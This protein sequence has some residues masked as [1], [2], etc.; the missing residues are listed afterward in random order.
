MYMQ[1]KEKEKEKEKKERERERGGGG[2]RRKEEREGPTWAERGDRKKKQQNNAGPACRPAT[3]VLHTQVSFATTAGSPILGSCLLP[4]CIEAV[5]VG[6]KVSNILPL[7]ILPGS[8][9]MR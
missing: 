2:R 4:L 1:E 7:S 8:H 6:C 9:N 3:V 5:E